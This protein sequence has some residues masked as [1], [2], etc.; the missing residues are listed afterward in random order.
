VSGARGRLADGDAELA[1]CRHQIALLTQELEETNRGLIALHAELESARQAEAQLA[2]IVH[3]SGDA[4]F[5]M[6]PEGVIETWNPGAERLFG[7]R[8]G[9]IVGQPGT[10]LI[11]EGL[12]EERESA[13]KRLQA[14][15]PA[16]RYDSRRRRKDGSL[17]DV[18]VT[19]SAMRDASGAVTGYSAVL[20][21][22]TDRL[23]TEAELA[24]ARAQQEVLAERDRMARD[25]HDGVIQRLFA[26]GMVLQG[27]MGLREVAG[28]TARIDEVI[29]ELDISIREIREA[30]FTLRASPRQP[31]SLRAQLLELVAD[32]ERSLGFTLAVSIQGAVA[33]V[34]PDIAAEV[35]A[36]AREALSNIAR[37][38]HA[39]A[40]SITITAGADLVLVIT[41]NGRG[42]GTASRSSG[43]RNMRERARL[44]GGSFT[45]TSAPG[46]GTRLEWRVPLPS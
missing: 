6:S 13:L 23:R 42:I 43:L 1:A 29:R 9:E 32:A 39:S 30:I 33:T 20:R 26:A 41:D 34:R 36:V 45:V 8:A 21:D 27:A 46:E 4:M 5:S 40:A 10:V 24:E 22:I 12:D 7:Y 37:H 2:A 11:P 14:G 28:M 35:S 17:V 38:A 19:L 18:A 3:S 31:A 15:E 25:L 16:T 44:L